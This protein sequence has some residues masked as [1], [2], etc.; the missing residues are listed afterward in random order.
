MNSKVKSEEVGRSPGHSVIT[1]DEI[2]LC[3][4]ENNLAISCEKLVDQ[5]GKLQ[6][7]KQ[8]AH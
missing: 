5:Q 4:D 7:L 3:E 2:V 1:R 6:F 8:V